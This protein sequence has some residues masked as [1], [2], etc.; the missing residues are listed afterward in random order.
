MRAGGSPRARAMV[1]TSSRLAGVCFHFVY[2]NCAQSLGG[3]VC[4]QPVPEYQTAAERMHPGDEVCPALAQ[5]VSAHSRVCASAWDTL[6]DMA[7]DALRVCQNAALR[8]IFSPGE[9]S[10]RRLRPSTSQ[11]LLSRPIPSQVALCS[12]VCCLH[13]AYAQSPRP[14]LPYHTTH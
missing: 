11:N 3:L 14:T 13:P 12:L 9:V 5:G 2:T 10:G 6:C 7:A 8:L 1:R 4:W